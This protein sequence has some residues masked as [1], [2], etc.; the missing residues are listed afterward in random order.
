MIDETD[1]IDVMG[2]CMSCGFRQMVAYHSTISKKWHDGRRAYKVIQQPPLAQY[3]GGCEG[4]LKWFVTDEDNSEVASKPQ[5]APVQLPALPDGIL[6]SNWPGVGQP[7]IKVDK[8]KERG[9]K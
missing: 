5:A 3:C 8:Q 7:I 1:R 6:V 9:T 2:S 4:L